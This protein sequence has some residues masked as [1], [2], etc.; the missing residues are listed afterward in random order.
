MLKWRRRAIAIAVLL[1]L[2]A[3]AALAGLAQFELSHFGW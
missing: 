2:G 1:V 3:S